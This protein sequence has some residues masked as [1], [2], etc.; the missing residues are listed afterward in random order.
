MRFYI[1]IGDPNGPDAR[2]FLVEG[3]SME[4]VLEAQAKTLENY[5]KNFFQ[6]FAKEPE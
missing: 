4:R 5:G 6:N 2:N 3:P 1:P